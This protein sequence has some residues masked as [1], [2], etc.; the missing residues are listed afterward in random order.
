MK[1]DRIRIKKL[2]N[3]IELHKNK[4]AKERDALRDLQDEIEEL[5]DCES[6]AVRDFEHAIDTLSQ[7][8]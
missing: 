7:Y 3:Q 1:M 4:I 8:L 6:E 2:V 5:A